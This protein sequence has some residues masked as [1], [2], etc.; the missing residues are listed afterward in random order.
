MKNVRKEK[1]N[2]GLF[3]PSG[4]WMHYLWTHF[5]KNG[6]LIRLLFMFISNWL[7]FKTPNS[8]LGFPNLSNMLLQ[9]FVTCY[10][11]LPHRSSFQFS[12]SSKF[13]GTLIFKLQVKVSFVQFFNNSM[14]FRF[15][16]S[17]SLISWSFLFVAFVKHTF[18]IQSAR[19]MTG[20]NMVWTMFWEF[21]A[22]VIFMFLLSTFQLGSRIVSLKYMHDISN[23]HTLLS[24]LWFSFIMFPNW[25]TS[26]APPSFK[27]II[28]SSLVFCEPPSL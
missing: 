1:I 3:Q 27:A 13:F 9:L 24:T 11:R 20:K 14:I 19:D 7:F 22:K 21:L 15:L 5:I 10:Y 26:Q 18:H 16:Q 12:I 25:Q 23:I 6:H 17:C 28:P 2:H 8:I 4:T